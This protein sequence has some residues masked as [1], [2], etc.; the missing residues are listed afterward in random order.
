MESTGIYVKELK[1][2]NS[3]KE[4]S[5][6]L[7]LKARTGDKIAE[8]KLAKNYLLLVVKIAREYLNMGV[9]YGDLIQEGNIGLLKSIHK[10][11]ETKGS[12]FSSCA[13]FWI[14]AGITRNCLFNKKVVKLPENIQELMKSDRWNG[15]DYREY[16]IDKPNDEGDSMSDTI[17]DTVN[18]DRFA[19]NEESMILKAK[20]TNILKFLKPRDADI[21]KAC[22]G[23]DRADSLDYEEAAELFN[24]TPTRISQIVRESVKQMRITHESLPESKTKEVEIISAIYGM[25]NYT[26]DVTD[27]VVDLYMKKENIKCSN[28]LGGDPCPGVTKSLSIQYIFEEEILTKRFT[29]GTIVKF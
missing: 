23:I 7:V 14:K 4:E 17:A 25:D 8:E 28:R 16:S 6:E 1:N 2:L 9:E 20:V 19:D 21:V 5:L 18:Y 24:L 13:R 12:P 29:E 3:T 10:F 11:D 26:V 22:Y 15:I 27:K